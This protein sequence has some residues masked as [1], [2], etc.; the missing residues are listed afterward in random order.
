M[1]E[2]ALSPRET[3]CLLLYARLSVKE[4]A[5]QLKLSIKTISTHLT[6]AQ[7]KLRLDSR[8]Q[9]FVR[10]VEMKLENIS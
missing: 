2:K 7:I 1:T 9:L 5:G 8:R 3:E 6:R 10:A 4:I